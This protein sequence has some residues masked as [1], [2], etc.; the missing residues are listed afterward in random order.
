M[1]QRSMAARNK[2]NQVVIENTREVSRTPMRSEPPRATSCRGSTA[3]P[4]H[5]DGVQPIQRVINDVSDGP[6]ERRTQPGFLVEGKV[7]FPLLTPIDERRRVS[8]GPEE[9][10]MQPGCLV[11]DKVAF[12]LLTPLSTRAS[13]QDALKR[14]WPP[15]NVDAHA[16]LQ[17][18]S[19]STRARQS[20]EEERVID[21][22]T[23]IENLL[24]I[25]EPEYHKW[26]PPPRSLNPVEY[27]PQ[28]VMPWCCDS[29]PEVDEVFCN[30]LCDSES[31]C[32]TES[33]ASGKS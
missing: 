7:V 24:W 33:E 10:R 29:E 30:S 19:T 20:K 26:T 25:D 28:S 9:R 6:D 8:D 13:L 12:P 1:K 18:A 17:G 31:V 2:K 23:E 32:D 22:S 21:R 4:T 15:T 14:Q 27:D 11:E 3:N 16:P 5:D